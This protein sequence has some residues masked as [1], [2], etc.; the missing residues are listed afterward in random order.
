MDVLK[1]KSIVL[2]RIILFTLFFIALFIV[3]NYNSIEVHADAVT[4]DND[5]KSRENPYGDSGLSKSFEADYYDCYVPYNLTP[6]D[7]GGWSQGSSNASSSTYNS[8]MSEDAKSR[9]ITAFV[10]WEND[11]S[12]NF[13]GSAT[14]SYEESTGMTIYTDGN[15][16]KYYVT[17][18]QNFFY[19]NSTAGT[20]GFPGFSIAN[21]GQIFDVILTDGTCIHFVVGDANAIQHTNAGS[22]DNES[23]FDVTYD[24][25]ELLIPQYKHIFQAQSGNT[26]EVWG[27]TSNAT[28]KFS[29]KYNIGNGDDQ[30]RVAYYRMYNAFIKNNPQRSSGVSGDVSYSYGDVSISGAGD[31][32]NATDSMGNVITSE[33]DLVG[34]GGLKNKIGDNQTKV[35]FMSRDNLS[36]GEAYSVATVGEN[37]ALLKE[38]NVIDTVRVSV[39]FVGL[40]LVFYS[41]LLLVAYLFDYTNSFLEI[42]L[43]KIIT[44]GYL[45]Y[46]DDELAKNERGK[47][48]SKR[49]LFLVVFLIII[50]CL[51]ISGGVLRAVMEIM[52]NIHDKIG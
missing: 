10:N 18:I 31:G 42:S 51:F 36:V 45:E 13:F 6:L 14:K 34:M 7:I 4:I 22:D 2:K 11:L 30:N 28:S 38:A 9:K 48:S 41:V 46:S 47:A 49:L 26:L 23:S 27:K 17:A 19:N 12:S 52:M 29:E 44:F 21:R 32:E 40:C 8:P 24:F 43:V 5:G 3:Y 37:I 1:A 15:G 35:N 16:T 50:G 39:V 33:W 20:N 25:T